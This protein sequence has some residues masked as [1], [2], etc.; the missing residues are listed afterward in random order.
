MLRRNKS[1]ESINTFLANSLNVQDPA[2]DQESIFS[3]ETLVAAATPIFRNRIL[4][5]TR[6][7]ELPVVKGLLKS[8]LLLYSSVCALK[9]GEPPLLSTQLNKLHFIK[10]NAPIITTFIHK[11]GL[12]Q[13]YCKIYFKILQNNLTCY[14]LMF[15]SG[16]NMVVFN[17]A[18]KPH[19]DTIYKDTKIRVYG[20][21]GASSTFGNAAM[22]MLLL[23]DSSSSLA[24]GIDE[25]K[26]SEMDSIKQL[27]VSNQPESSKLY[28]AVVKQRRNEVL[29]LLSLAT[30][31]APIPFATFFDLGGEKIDGLKIQGSIR[32]FESSLESGENVSHDSLVLCTMMLTL[33][34]QEQLKMRGHNKPSFVNNINELGHVRSI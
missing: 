33:I 23:N 29:R 13:E 9:N 19:C 15:S 24:D 2:C 4:S 28:D 1:E 18:L 11:N 30:N 10:K 25:Q 8:E 14:V 17:N 12:K 6:L 20:A 31:I 5:Y 7:R 27:E 3:E 22:K 26:L 16:Q 32:L 34:E 21:S